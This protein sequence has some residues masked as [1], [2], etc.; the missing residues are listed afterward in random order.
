[1]LSL[2]M[3][4]LSGL[5]A[6][7]LPLPFRTHYASQSL[8]QTALH[9]FDETEA[10]LDA[11]EAG[12]AIVNDDDQAISLKTEDFAQLCRELDLGAQYQAHLR[13][14]F[15]SGGLGQSRRGGLCTRRTVEIPGTY[16]FC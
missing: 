1:M 14:V 5:P 8:L 11:F 9:N 12:T 16:H 7:S 15:D 2:A 13:T 4:V 6:T 10:Q 3:P